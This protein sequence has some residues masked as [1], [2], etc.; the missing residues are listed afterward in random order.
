MTYALNDVPQPV[1]TVFSRV[2]RVPSEQI[3]LESNSKTTPN[4]D[5]LRH[6]EL[7]VEIEEV[8]KTSFS[9]VE[10]FALTSVRGFCDMLVKKKIDLS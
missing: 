4:W 3:T 2:L 8:Y 6:V 10:V 5:S 9:A 1:K 7:V